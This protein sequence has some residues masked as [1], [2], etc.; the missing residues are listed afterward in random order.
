MF[1][2]R[3]RNAEVVVDVKMST[4]KVAESVGI[5]SQRLP[6]GISDVAGRAKTSGKQ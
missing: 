6:A 2:V 3:I 1:D 5:Y 4:R